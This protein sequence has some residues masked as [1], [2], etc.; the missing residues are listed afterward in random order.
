MDLLV[1]SLEVADLSLG[2]ASLPL[3]ELLLE[4]VLVVLLEEIV[5]GLDVGTEDVISVLL[6]VVSTG[7]LA[8]LS[9]GLASLTGGDLLLLSVVAWESLGV[10]GDV[11]STI[12][13][14]LEG[15]EDSITSGSS[16]KTNIEESL[17]GA[18][19]LV[20]T[21]LIDIEEFTVSFLNTLIEVVETKLGQES[22][23]DEETGGVGGGIVGKTSLETESLELSG[24]S[25]SEDLITLDG[26]VDHLNNDSAVGSSNAESVLL[27]IVLVLVLLDKSSSGLV[28]S[29]SLSSPSELDLISGVVSVTLEDLD[30]THVVKLGGIK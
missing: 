7:S 5:V 4:L 9:D 14:T 26:S 28:V 23:G 2:E 22:S 12:N 15:T 16:N 29:L 27:G 18:L 13:S 10:V 11:N 21:L 8:L 24:V 6:S 3:G 25:L 20:N 19:V 1:E 30:E 17:E